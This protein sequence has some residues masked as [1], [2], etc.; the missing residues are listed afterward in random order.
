M[1]PNTDNVKYVTLFKAMVDDG[2]EILD[3]IRF[4]S[5]KPTFKLAYGGYP[6]DDKGGVITQELF[7]NYHNVLYPGITDY[8]ENYVFPTAQ[9]Q[10]YIHLGLGCRLYT[11]D[12]RSHIRTLNNATVQFWSILTLIAINEFN[13]RIREEGLHEHVQVT[14]SIYDSI[15]T[16]NTA[17]PE[18]LKWVNDNLIEL[19]CCKY[20]EGETIHNVAD[21][22]IGLNWAKLHNVPNNASVDEI[23]AVLETL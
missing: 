12:A 4:D 3:K 19:M 9:R 10:G 16:Q 17:D 1:G 7:D 20:L 8:R 23:A 21:G 18:I 2:N 15:Y 13:H 22:Q 14:S 11:N 6:D 5:K